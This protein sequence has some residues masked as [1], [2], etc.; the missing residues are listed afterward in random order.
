MRNHYLGVNTMLVTNR[1]LTMRKIKRADI[2]AAV[3]AAQPIK[4]A[5]DEAYP[6]GDHWQVENIEIIL[7]LKL[8][9]RMLA[10]MSR[11]GYEAAARFM[12]QPPRRLVANGLPGYVLPGWNGPPR[13]DWPASHS[14]G[15]CWD[16]IRREVH[17]SIV[18]TLRA[19][20]H[21]YSMGHDQDLRRWRIEIV[22]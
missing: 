16:G 14:P 3:A 22:E 19:I 4:S 5:W 20:A 8:W 10:K 6:K 7:R 13:E 21:G 17:H 12:E 15:T 18:D 9:P 11:D 1:R 2:L